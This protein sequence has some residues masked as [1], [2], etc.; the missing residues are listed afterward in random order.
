MSIND[1]TR[2]II[3]PSITATDL[4]PDRGDTIAFHCPSGLVIENAQVMAKDYFCGEPQ[5][6]VRYETQ[7]CVGNWVRM[8]GWVGLSEVLS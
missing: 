4:V 1:L 3:R 2:L 6:Y 8:S 7:N 5:L